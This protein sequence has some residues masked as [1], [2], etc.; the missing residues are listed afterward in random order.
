[1]GAAY[2][3]EEGSVSHSGAKDDE[4]AVSEPTAQSMS[5]VGD[6]PI[7]HQRFAIE[8]VDTLGSLN[9]RETVIEQRVNDLL[10]SG[11]AAERLERV[12]N[13]ASLFRK[14]AIFDSLGDQLNLAI[15][16]V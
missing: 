9:S 8:G 5:G 16:I 6:K 15:T 1:M 4:R 12:E 13:N 11:L 2:D 14:A 10:L 3:D 7:F